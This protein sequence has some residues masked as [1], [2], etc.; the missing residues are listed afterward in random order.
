MLEEDFKSTYSMQL[1][2]Y[3]TAIRNPPELKKKKIERNLSKTTCRPYTKNT[4]ETKLKEIDV[5]NTTPSVK[6]RQ[7]SELI[8]KF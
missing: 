7:S 3:R 5:L 4:I 2:S 8:E 1:I 6:D